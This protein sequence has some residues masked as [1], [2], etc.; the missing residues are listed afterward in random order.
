[1]LRAC[2]CVGGFG[3][4]WWVGAIDFDGAAVFDTMETTDTH[5]HLHSTV[6][7][8]TLITRNTECTAVLVNANA[9]HVPRFQNVDNSLEK[10][11]VVDTRSEPALF[12]LLGH[13]FILLVFSTVVS[14][15]WPMALSEALFFFLCYPNLG[16]NLNKSALRRSRML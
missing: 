8:L 16:E 7:Q 3:R 4:C 14:Q 12:P 15:V 11:F 5:R 1:M 13:T 10:Q 9:F 2:I 6:E